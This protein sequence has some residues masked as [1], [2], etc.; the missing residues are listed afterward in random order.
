MVRACLVVIAFLTFCL[1]AQSR[2]VESFKSGGWSGDAFISDTTGLFSSCAA[3]A[4]YRSGISMSVEVD[5]N[6]SW[7][8]GFSS[9]GWTMTTGENINLQYRI[10]RGSWQSGTA[11][12]MSPQLARMPMPADGYIVRRFRRG[13]VLYVRDSQNSYQF[14]LTGTSRLLARLARCVEQN[15]ARHGKGPGL[16]DGPAPAPAEKTPVV[17]S[18][19]PEAETPP[20]DPKLQIEATQA[21][22]NLMAV[23]GQTGLKLI[24]E[25]DRAEEFKGLHAVAG[26]DARIVVAHV[27][28][29]GSFVSDNQ[30]MAN[31]ISDAAT[32]CGGD[33]KA[34]YS[35]DS[36][37]GS[38]LFNGR[39]SCSAG[40]VERLERY[41]IVT[42]DDDSAL[43]F[44]VAE[45]SVGEGGGEA[46]GP[47][48]ELSDD[49]FHGAIVKITD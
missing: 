32:D 24:A 27:Y 46:S 17:Q 45:T 38:E 5:S 43:V 20:I 34:A 4:R 33:F 48:T 19:E 3:I 2:V 31:L 11:T 1:P 35:R 22:F 16:S 6:Y 42:R 47:A 12:A 40:D 21:L 8:I 13:N 44:G 25:A 36:V 49:A 29:E 15:V 18:P 28:P 9:P 30:L 26:D 14:R 23:T 37:T 7:W 41:A 39:S 10:D